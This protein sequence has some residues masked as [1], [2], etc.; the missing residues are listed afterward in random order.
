MDDL[1]A[2][3]TETEWVVR[4]NE[5]G[6]APYETRDQA[7]EV[8]VIYGWGTSDSKVSVLHRTVTVTYGPWIEE[9]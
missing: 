6:D 2:I 4:W 8:A 7:V 1:T 3:R 9:A 5:G